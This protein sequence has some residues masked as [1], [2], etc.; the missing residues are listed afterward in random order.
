M[1]LSAEGL[2]YVIVRNLRG[3]PA[4]KLIPL[5]WMIR[6]LSLLT[7]MRMYFISKDR[8]GV[9]QSLLSMSFL[10]TENYI[11]KIIIG[12]VDPITFDEV[13]YSTYMYLVEMTSLHPVHGKISNV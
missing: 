10:N 11:L 13:F 12:I 8:K 9:S 4:Y 1:H 3:L 2:R 6:Q 5:N 7:Q